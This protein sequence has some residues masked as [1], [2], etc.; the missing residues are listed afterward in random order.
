M[1]G[2]V[3]LVAAGFGHFPAYTG[4]G[5]LHHNGTVW[6]LGM[7]GGAGRKE[8]LKQAEQSVG[9]ISECQRQG[10]IFTCRRSS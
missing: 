4:S 3:R 6:N 10:Y 8:P 2:R 5:E 1:Q 7:G 9:I